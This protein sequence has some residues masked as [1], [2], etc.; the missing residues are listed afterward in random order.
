MTVRWSL[1][2]WAILGLALGSREG[3]HACDSQIPEEL[4]KLSESIG[5]RPVPGFWDRPGMV[6]PPYMYGVLDGPKEESAAFWS[7]CKS[8]EKPYKLAV[9]KSGKIVSTVSWQNYPGG[10]SI[11]SSQRMPLSEFRFVDNPA[12]RGPNDKMTQHAP[13]RSEYDGVITLFYQQGE[14]WLFEILE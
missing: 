14:R 8:Q 5:C 11:H 2:L 12:E 4:S 7:Y 6:E 10:L 3:L 1:S 9:V 13:L